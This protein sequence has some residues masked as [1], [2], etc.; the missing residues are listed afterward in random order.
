M[1]LQKADPPGAVID[2]FRD[3]QAA[4]ADQERLRNEAQ[5]YANDVIPRARGEAEKVRLEAEAYK[6]QT[7]AEA[8][9]EVSRYL[10]IF[11]EYQRAKD[12]TR[13]RLYYETLESVRSGY[14]PLPEV[15]KRAA[16]SGGTQ[17]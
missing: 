9:G 6:E 15:Q 3:V 5:A 14:L 8:E 1:K 13:K 10:A 2:A 4:R 11:N 12:V 16:E 7:V 17:R